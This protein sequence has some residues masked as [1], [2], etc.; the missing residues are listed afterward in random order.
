[1][2]LELSNYSKEQMKENKNLNEVAV[3][4]FKRWIKG[5]RIMKIILLFIFVWAEYSII[6]ITETTEIMD[7]WWKAILVT[8]QKLFLNGVFWQQQKI[9]NWTNH[10]NDS[11]LSFFLFSHHS[12]GFASSS[13]AVSKDADVVALKS[14]FQ[15][16][17]A[18]VIVHTVLWC[19]GGVLWLYDKKKKR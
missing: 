1:M 8:W 14:M 19:K 4:K 2:A 5:F 3:W 17:L 6:S 15:H 11:F 13:L 16:F 7:W 10:R 9:M 12:V 18:D